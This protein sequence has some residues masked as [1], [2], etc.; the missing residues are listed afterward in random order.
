MTVHSAYL[1]A[2]YDRKTYK[3]NL[4]KAVEVL[5]EVQ[6]ETPFDAI[7]F[8]GTSGAAFS[9][10]LAHILDVSLMCVRKQNE[11]SHYARLVEGYG[12]STNFIIVDDFMA[13][14]DTLI[15]IAREIKRFY[16]DEVKK[17]KPNLIG[18]LFYNHENF[19]TVQF[20]SIN[21][22]YLLFLKGYY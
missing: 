4:E 16:L 5:K 8:T 1:T 17:E 13:S 10:P 6:K 20:K 21:D 19:G 12:G 2:V 14:G 15:K 3:K 18:T 11:N 22:A 7:A 9:Y